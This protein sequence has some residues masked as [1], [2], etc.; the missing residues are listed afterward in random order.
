MPY[1]EPHVT[2]RY[3]GD[4]VDVPMTVYYFIYDGRVQTETVHFMCPKDKLDN[5]S[6]TRRL[7]LWDIEGAGSERLRRMRNSNKILFHYTKPNRWVCVKDR[8]T[9]SDTFDY[10]MTSKEQTFLALAA[11]PV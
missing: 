5:H 6:Y 11:E 2:L 9:G 8:K 7:L 1:F 10:E 3:V 4:T